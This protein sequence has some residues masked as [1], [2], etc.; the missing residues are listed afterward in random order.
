M[1]CF[2]Q[3]LGFLI[4]MFNFQRVTWFFPPLH[5]AGWV[6]YRLHGKP[7]RKT[8][9]ATEGEKLDATAKEWLKVPCQNVARRVAQT[10]FCHMIVED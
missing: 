4:S 5:R 9:M 1:I 7:L 8:L 3:K 6:L 2:Y 10:S